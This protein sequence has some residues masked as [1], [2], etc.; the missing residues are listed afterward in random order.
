MRRLTF[1]FA[2]ISKIVIDPLYT[3]NRNHASGGNWSDFMTK[4]LITLPTYSTHS[5]KNEWMSRWSSRMWLDSIQPCNTLHYTTIHYTTL[6]YTA[7]HDNTLHHTTL[8]D[9][10][11]HC[12]TLHSSILH[13]TMHSNHSIN[14]TYVL[15]MTDKKCAVMIRFIFISAM[16]VILKCS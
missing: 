10:T 7:L 8:H 13:Y 4:Y 15:T 3:F 12:T 14:I 9:T 11:L 1:P 5:D 16:N 6:H 2:L